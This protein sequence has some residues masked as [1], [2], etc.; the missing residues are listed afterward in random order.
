MTVNNSPALDAIAHINPKPFL[1]RFIYEPGWIIPSAIAEDNLGGRFEVRIP[2]RFLKREN[3]AVVQRKLWGTGVY[4]DDSDVVAS[5]TPFSPNI[6]HSRY[7]LFS[8][9]PFSRIMSLFVVLYHTSTL[10]PAALHRPTDM[11]AHFLILPTLQHYTASTQNELRSRGWKVHDGFSIF[12]ERVEKI[13]V[14][15][16]EGGW[17]GRKRRLDEEFRMGI[18]SEEIGVR[19]LATA[20]TAGFKEVKWGAEQFMVGNKRRTGFVA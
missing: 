4:T 19:D 11:S 7:S 8:H 12:L 13:N 3:E 9:L 20:A 17:R 5:K 15:E 16:A 2:Q 14:G 18:D 10:P 6:L 1:G